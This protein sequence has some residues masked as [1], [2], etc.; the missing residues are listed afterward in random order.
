VTT[1]FIITD[2]LQALA[3]TYPDISAGKINIL[4]SAP[5]VLR[6]TTLNA[7]PLDGHIDTKTLA[8]L[9]DASA[10]ASLEILSVARNAGHPAAQSLARWPYNNHILWLKVACLK[11]EIWDN[12][13]EILVP[14]PDR[15]DLEWL[16]KSPLQDVLAENANWTIREIPI[17]TQGEAFP[18]PS[19]LRRFQIAGWQIFGFRF[20]L[21][22]WSRL[23]VGGPRGTA[24]ILRDVELLRET[25]FSLALRGFALKQLPRFNPEDAEDAPVD[26]EAEKIVGAAYDRHIAPLMGNPAAA[27]AAR[28]VGLRALGR[29]ISI[30][31]TARTFWQHALPQ[32][33]QKKPIMVLSNAFMRPQVDALSQVCAARGYPL[34]MFQHGVTMEISDR[35]GGYKALAENT[36]ASVFY[37]FNP[38]SERLHNANKMASGEVVNVGLPQQ[39]RSVAKKR[40]IHATGTEPP[41]WYISTALYTGNIGLL[42]KGATDARIAEIEI[43]IIDHILA[44]LPH[45]VLFKTY[46]GMKYADPDPITAA[47]RMQSNITLEERPLDLRYLMR[48]ARVLVTSNASSTLGWCLVS[49]RP[50]IYIEHS[51]ILPLAP[52]ARKA[53]EPSVLFVDAGQSDFHA[54]AKDFLSL[55]LAEIDTEWQARRPAR[56]RAIAEYFDGGNRHAGRSA[57]LDLI[58]RAQKSTMLPNRNTKETALGMAS[59]RRTP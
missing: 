17:Q 40:N 2:S 43:D 9:N 24:F 42:H 35:V 33:P 55:S 18:Q 6:D 5:A 46:P 49:R 12:R 27:A 47:A 59:P 28:K 15:K 37:V 14:V 8:A 10:A 31:D 22:L 20:F 58:A 36:A 56:E 54:R 1:K 11:S 7:K 52:D 48:R 23:P 53:L 21:W 50:L 51:E 19:V 34:A 41:I 32:S 16:Y 4:S 38:A 3:Q 13:G 25:A 39:Y 26:Q 30:W 45:R 29:D 57:A 44:K